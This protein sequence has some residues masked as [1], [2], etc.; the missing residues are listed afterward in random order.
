MDNPQRQSGQKFIKD[1]LDS[2]DDLMSLYPQ[3]QLT[4]IWVPGHSEIDDNERADKEARKGATGPSLSQLYN[5]EPLKSAQVRNIKAE[6][7]K[8]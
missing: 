2:I 7:K 8:Q 1:I 6:A 4:I 3:P 5:H